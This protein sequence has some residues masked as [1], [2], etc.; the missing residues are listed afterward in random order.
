MSRVL[1]IALSS[2]SLLLLVVVLGEE[3][4]E[5]VEAALPLGTPL[6]DPVLGPAHRRRPHP[7]R[8]HPPD[9]LGVD[10]AALLQHLEMLHDGR[11]RDRQR[12]C[13]LAD[14]GRA[15]AELLD[16][17]PARPIAERVEHPVDRVA[18]VT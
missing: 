16:D 2:L 4:A 13:Q 12:R 17:L 15:A 9:L 18:L 8:P 6:C 5:T 10:E 11:Q 14:R 3:L 7:A 1:S